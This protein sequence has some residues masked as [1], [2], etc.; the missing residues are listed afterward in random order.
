LLIEAADGH[1]IARFSGGEVA[2]SIS[3]LTLTR[4]PRGRVRT[5]SGKASFGVSGWVNAGRLPVVTTRGV[6]VIARHVWIGERTAVSIR[7]VSG[8]RL[9]IERAASSPLDG[10]FKAVTTC[11]ALA[12]DAEATP[13]WSPL[14]DAR[15]YALRGASL[16][17][18]DMPQ[19]NAIGALRKAPDQRAVLFFSR[20][21]RIG[22]VHVERHGDIVVDAWV[23]EHDVTA[24]PRG[25]TLDEPGNP[26]KASVARLALPG[27][28]RVV[29]TTRE[30]PLRASA[31]DGDPSIGTI[32]P[33]TETYVVEVTAGWVSVLPRALD[34]LPP[35]G[36]HFWVKRSDLSL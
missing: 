10:S 2:L 3:E 36:R 24:L 13:A 29:T 6:E 25:E 27:A 8:D 5:G 28:P 14:G 7:G 34:V 20:E 15:A 1:A 33:D 23:A 9:E 26:T 18:Y 12:F 30:V 21:Q 4:A 19:G 35:E 16:D 22:F 32:A 31:S 17:L 11:A